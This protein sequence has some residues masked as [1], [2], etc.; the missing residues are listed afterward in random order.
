MR[1]EADRQIAFDRMKSPKHIAG[2]AVLTLALLAPGSAYQ[3]GK[4]A[5]A[6]PPP[7]QPPASSFQPGRPTLG[8]PPATGPNDDRPRKHRFG[9]WFQDHKNLS[10][11]QQQEALERDPKFQELPAERQARLRDRLRWLNSLPQD[12]RERVISRMGHWEDMS[13]E[14]RERWKQFQNRLSGMAQERQQALR[15]T[16]RSLRWMSPEDRQHIFESDHFKQDF[17]D[18]EK[19]LLNSMLDAADADARKES[20]ARPPNR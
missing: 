2:T 12:Q 16:F 8:P 13:P 17:S 14:Q 5:Q 6:G 11:E 4:R 1:M 15:Q 10:P 3:K 19:A 18:D 20:A 9:A 7:A